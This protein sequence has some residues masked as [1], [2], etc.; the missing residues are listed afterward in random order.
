MLTL[1]LGQ[2]LGAGAQ[3]R[4]FLWVEGTQSLEPL[5]TASQGLYWQEV[6]VQSWVSYQ[7]WDL[8]Q[9]DPG[10]LTAWLNACPAL[11]LC[12]TRARCNWKPLLN[13][14][15]A[16]TNREPAQTREHREALVSI[17]KPGVWADLLGIMETVV[18][19]PNCKWEATP[20]YHCQWLHYSNL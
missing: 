19:L 15:S 8:K 3:S 16:V 9:W 2:K 14:C 10:F 12:L 4:S 11:V 18:P 1:G 6:G 20:S 13:L 5:P 7:T 17:R